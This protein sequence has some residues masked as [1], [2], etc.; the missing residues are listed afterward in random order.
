MIEWR[1]GG[2][3]PLVMIENCFRAIDIERRSK[4]LRDPRKIDIFA[5]KLTVAVM[6][7]VHCAK[8]SSLKHDHSQ[9]DVKNPNQ[10]HSQRK[11]CQHQCLAMLHH[12]SQ[13]RVRGQI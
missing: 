1:N 11:A 3:E 4:F 2:I 5:V 10:Y 12:L 6:E 7:R 9:A 13:N 8:C